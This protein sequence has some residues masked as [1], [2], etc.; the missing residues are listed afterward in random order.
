MEHLYT[1]LYSIP[2]L[3]RQRQ[4]DRPRYLPLVTDAEPI[5]QVVRLQ[6]PQVKET[7]PDQIAL[8]V[9]LNFQRLRR[10]AVA[11]P[12]TQALVPLW[13]LVQILHAAR[14]LLLSAVAH[15]NE[16]TLLTHLHLRLPFLLAD[17]ARLVYH[18]RD[19]LVHLLRTLVNEVI[20]KRSL[21]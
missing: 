11:E 14:A 2:L 1:S 19:A 9:H 21:P 18:D 12:K 6:L 10:V 15:P 5:V 13:V 20:R 7:A 17:E 8:V 4:S 3:E 16:S